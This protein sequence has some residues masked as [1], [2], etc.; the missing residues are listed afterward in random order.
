MLTACETVTGDNRAALGL[1]GV[2]IRAGERGAIASLWQAKDIVT[3]Q[4]TQDFYQFLK[5]PNLNQAQALQQAQIRAIR[6]GPDV[7]PGI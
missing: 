3:A 5:N 6:S 7:F 4:I 1:A 2:A